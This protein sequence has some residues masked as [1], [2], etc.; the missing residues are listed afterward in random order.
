MTQ[1]TYSLSE[2]Q[3]IIQEV[4]YGTLPDNYWIHA[5]IASI[6]IKSGHCYLELVEKAPDG[7][8]SAK[9]RAT[10]WNQRYALLSNYF[11]SHTNSTLQ[12]GMQVLLAVEV[13]YHPVYGLSLNITNIDP[14]YTLGALA[15]ARQETLIRLQQEGLLEIQQ[16]LR[17][18]TLT[19]RLAILSADTAAGYGDFVDQLNHSPYRFQMRLFPC[20]MQGDNTTTSIQQALAN[21]TKDIHAY[22]AVIIIRGGGATTDLNCFD[23]Y[24]LCKVCALFPLPIITGIGHTRDISLLDH[25]AHTALKTPTAVAAFLVGRMDRLVDQIGSMQ[26]RLRLTADRQILIRKHRIELIEQKLLLRSPERIYQMG[27][28]LLTLNGT[29]VRSTQQV[30]PGQQV[31]THLKDGTI[32]SIIQ[33]I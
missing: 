14:S 27:Y 19:Q 24:D 9:T 3:S 22:D 16:Q 20:I 30:T 33:K 7:K 4:L 25:V 21:I 13:S 26:Q 12:V 28:S 6:Q 2:F 23:H 31:T 5:E 29:I 32:E 11:T 8:L 18:P 17:L 10:C 15:K 1:Q